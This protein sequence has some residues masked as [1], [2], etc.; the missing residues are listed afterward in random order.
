MAGKVSSLNIDDARSIYWRAIKYTFSFCVCGIALVFLMDL[1]PG[2]S[3]YKGIAYSLFIAFVGLGTMIVKAPWMLLVFGLAGY[4]LKRPL[5]TLIAI[6]LMSALTIPIINLIN[7]PGES[8]GN[9][10]GVVGILP[11]A[12]IMGSIGGLIAVR[13]PSAP[14]SR[15]SEMMEKTPTNLD[16]S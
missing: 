1:L 16:E 15:A 8:V 12:I 9:Y 3:S 11:V 4:L 13:A 10:Y 2:S 6:L 14:G 5:F 7:S